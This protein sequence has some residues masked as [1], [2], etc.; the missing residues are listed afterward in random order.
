MTLFTKTKIGAL[1]LLLLPFL[2]IAQNGAFW[3]EDFSNHTGTS[4]PPNWITS[5]GSDNIFQTL[6][7]RCGIPETCPPDTIADSFIRDNFKSSTA[8]NGYVYSYSNPYP[9]E[10]D[11][12]T[13]NHLSQL[14]SP[15]ILLPNLDELYLEFQSFLITKHVRE[16]EGARLFVQANNEEW[17]EHELYPDVP[18]Y[19]YSQ[20]QKTQNANVFFVDLSDYSNANSIRL[21]WEWMGQEEV[22]WCLDD[23]KLFDYNPLDIRTIVNLGDFSNGLG[24]WTIITP[25]TNECSWEWE[26]FGYYGDAFLPAGNDNKFINSP[27]FKTGAVVVNGDNCFTSDS[28]P[29]ISL[30]DFPLFRSELISPTIDLSNTTEQVLLDFFQVIRKLENE[31]TVSIASPFLFSYSTD[32]GMTWSPDEPL[33]ESL[34]S[35]IT[36]NTH[37]T[38]LLPTDLI[39]ESEV[40]IKFIFNGKLF[41]WGLDDIRILERAPHDMRISKDFFALPSSYSFP[42][43]QIDSIVF[44]A[45]IENFGT[46]SQTDIWLHI[47][48]ENTDTELIVY[49]DSLFIPL[50]L[51]LELVENQLF[52]EKYLPPSIPAHYQGTYRISSSTI[53]DVPDN[54]EISFR[55]E[56]TEDLFAKES[57]TSFGFKP[58]FRDYSWGNAFYLPNGDGYFA[59]SVF[60]TIENLVQM[61]GKDVQIELYEW[62]NNLTDSL[63][64]SPDEYTQIGFNEIEISEDMSDLIGISMEDISGNGEHPALKDN[65]QYFVVLRYMRPPGSNKDCF[66]ATSQEYDYSAMKFATDLSN[67][68][69]YVTLWKS[70]ASEI[71]EVVGVGNGSGYD[72]IPQIRLSITDAPTSIVKVS[73]PTEE[74]KLYPNPTN[75]NFSIKLSDESNGKILIYNNLGTLIYT[76]DNFSNGDNISVENLVSG[77]YFVHFIEDKSKQIRIGKLIKM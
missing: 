24:D 28:P 13:E 9:G 67:K 53:D 77:T 17:V 55:F 57:Q 34:A 19:P 1:L 75:T 11:T 35:N 72:Y 54:N 49:Q 58:P 18:N 30:D 52:T 50:A 42:V 60:F 29:V 40:K 68:L 8:F 59:D 33:N 14:N 69:R 71:F 26:S 36:Y 46:E 62:E 44:L 25:T 4:L 12:L 38:I 37:E 64:A 41:Y 6:W 10:N 31:N 45:D 5:D 32:N 23:C 65:T 74:L 56:V 7:Q 20:P 76:I 43:S 61:D 70:T 27:T 39:G 47:E 73:K 48:I 3:V 21:R 51:P 63:L 66:L 16:H 2:S 22:I 15:I